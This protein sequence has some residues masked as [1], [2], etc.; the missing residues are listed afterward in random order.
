MTP[1]SPWSPP[2]S[3]HRT[4]TSLRKQ[5]LPRY[6]FWFKH[7]WQS[8]RRGNQTITDPN[9]P[10]P[11]HGSTCAS[12]GINVAMQYV[13][14]ISGNPVSGFRTTAMHQHAHAIFTRLHELG[15]APRTWG[16][17][18]SDVKDA[19]LL[20]MEET[21]S[22][23]K[24]GAAHWKAH[25]IATQIYPSCSDDDSSDDN[26]AKASKRRQRKR[27]WTPR[28]SEDAQHKQPPS[29][30]VKNQ[31]QPAGAHGTADAPPRSPPAS[32]AH[33]PVQ[34]PPAES[35]TPRLPKPVFKK[36]LPSPSQASPSPQAKILAPNLQVLES[37]LS[38]KIRLMQ[39]R[40]SPLFFKVLFKASGTTI[41][42]LHRPLH[43]SP[44]LLRHTPAGYKIKHP[45]TSSTRPMNVSSYRTQSRHQIKA[46]PCSSPLLT[47]VP[48]V[49]LAVR[50]GK[51]YW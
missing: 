38:F 11:V 8:H 19:Y 34:S 32:P 10:A 12:Q 3:L 2:G 13:E 29:K 33:L 7:E 24:L 5:A 18:R 40:L 26:A 16:A 15:L 37:I 6:K 30:K 45:S 49:V 22:E 43:L 50:K 51:R 31:R 17:A 28:R 14:D 46:H 4:P 44:S 42:M 39:H 25:H 1:F 21:F 27:G 20:D 35:R 23:L 47:T 9:T 41:L 48:T 36:R